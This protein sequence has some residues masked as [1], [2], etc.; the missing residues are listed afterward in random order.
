MYGKGATGCR[1]ATPVPE[2][3]AGRDK[4][5][6]GMERGDDGCIKAVVHDKADAAPTSLLPSN[7][8][9]IAIAHALMAH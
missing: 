1:W 4:T 7:C 3:A 8:A 2:G 9:R 5:K 6:H